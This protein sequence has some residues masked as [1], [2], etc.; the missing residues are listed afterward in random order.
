MIS[1]NQLSAQDRTSSSI[2]MLLTS[3]GFLILTS[4]LSIESNANALIQGITPSSASVEFSKGVSNSQAALNQLEKNIN[5][6]WSSLDTN[7][8]SASEQELKTAKLLL[9]KFPDNTI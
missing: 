7:F 8:F 6:L 4:G 9:E 3:A 2:S 1:I 5:E